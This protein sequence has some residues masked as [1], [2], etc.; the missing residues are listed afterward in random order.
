MSDAREREDRIDSERDDLIERSLAA[1]HREHVPHGP[2]VEVTARTLSRLKRPASG[3]ANCDSNERSTL[4]TRIL[5][6]TFAQRI[7]A[8]VLVTIGALVL[9]FMFALFGGFG[10][11]SYAQVA[12][13]IKDAQSMTMKMTLTSPQLKE[14]T[15]QTKLYFLQPGMLRHEGT[16]GATVTRRDGERIRVLTLMPA[17]KSAQLIEANLTEAS[18]K[19]PDVVAEFRALAEKK[20]EP[21]DE[22]QIGDVKAKGFRVVSDGQ[23]VSLWAHPKTALPL[24]VE[25]D[26]PSIG[27]GGKV[28]LSEIAFDVK[29]DEKLFRLD[30]PEGYKLMENKVAV[31]IDLEA[32]VINLMRAYASTTGGTFPEKLDDWAAYGKALSTGKAKPD[33]GT[34]QA[35]SGAGAITA[36]LT[37][38][39]PGEDY[40]YTGRDAKLGDKDKIIFW[41]RDKAKGTYRAIYADL[42]AKDVTAEQ[43]LKT[44]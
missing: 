5:T 26:V 35:L 19:N 6:M 11:V 22:R 9:W 34:L 1:L 30:V 39:K 25:I 44:R 14:R 7:A 43:I 40:A 31:T 10:T 29:L 3:A 18:G 28:V 27:E 23:M 20:G 41:H 16:N 38:K 15:M 24:L 12:Q 13:Q 37:G 21:L 32:N 2:G 17:T 36:L 33:P 8:V 42:T 4:F